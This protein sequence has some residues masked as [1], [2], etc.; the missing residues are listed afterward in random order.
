MI[1][2]LL[3]VSPRQ[4]EEAAYRQSL[5]QLHSEF[6]NVTQ[7]L[8]QWAN[9]VHELNTSYNLSM[10]GLASQFDKLTRA[11][12]EQLKAISRDAL[13]PDAAHERQERVQRECRA[14]I[15]AVKSEIQQAPEPAKGGAQTAMLLQ[16]LVNS[17]T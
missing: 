10:K 11:F 1:F 6:K 13:A 4:Q 3:F 15:A 17:M 12:S 2:V 14:L 7:G 16:A 5:S 8:Q 9:S